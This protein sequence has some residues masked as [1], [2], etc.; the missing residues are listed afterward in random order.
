MMSHMKPMR[1]IATAA[2]LLAMIV[3]SGCDYE[4]T[5]HTVFDGPIPRFAGGAS[6]TPTQSEMI[7]KWKMALS[8]LWPETYATLEIGSN[9]RYVLLA[10]PPYIG[11]SSHGPWGMEDGRLRLGKWII[12]DGVRSDDAQHLR[13]EL[14]R[15]SA[16]VICG[17]GEG[18][19]PREGPCSIVLER[20][21]N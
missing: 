3:V 12:R 19:S 15:I 2:T 18:G 7:G 16:D 20:L 13:V 9:G 14:H 17:V 10:L 1:Q 6:A 8:N 5:P 11:Q 21:R 4:I